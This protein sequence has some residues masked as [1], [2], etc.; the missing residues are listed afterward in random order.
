MVVMPAS[1]SF[2]VIFINRLFLKNDW[3]T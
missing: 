3:L 1:F 2:L